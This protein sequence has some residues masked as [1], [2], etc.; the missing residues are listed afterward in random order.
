MGDEPVKGADVAM[1]NYGFMFNKQSDKKGEVI[2]NSAEVGMNTIKISYDGY[3]PIYSQIMVKKNKTVSKKIYLL[4]AITNFKWKKYDH[5]YYKQPYI[6]PL[7]KHIIFDSEGIKMLGY[8]KDP[9]KD[10]LITN[11]INKGNKNG[12]DQKYLSFKIKKD[13]NNWHTMEGGGFL[14]NIQ[15]N[16]NKISGYCIIVTQSGLKLYEIKNIDAQDFSDGKLGNISKVGNLLGQYKMG[17]VLLQHKIS[18]RVTNKNMSLW[19]DDKVLIDNYKLP[20]QYGYDFGPITSHSKHDCSQ[21]SYFT[22]S[23]IQMSSASEN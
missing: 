13:K 1:I 22:F 23:D 12:L 15:K 16:N 3:E 8:T 2:F 5:Y 18:M 7:S 19:C 10:F 14:F 11:D 20:H 9:L 6:P 17:D 21:Q 4:S